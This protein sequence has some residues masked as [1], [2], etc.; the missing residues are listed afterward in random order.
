MNEKT[1]QDAIDNI[2]EYVRKMCP[3]P[4]FTHG[5]ACNKCRF[6]VHLADSSEDIMVCMGYVAR[7]AGERYDEIRIKYGVPGIP[8]EMKQENGRVY[9]KCKI[10]GPHCEG[11][12]SI[13]TNGIDQMVCLWGQERNEE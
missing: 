5:E 12:I 3:Y 9:C 8:I 10:D 6:H 2:V 7:V 11:P 13:F 1:Y 4:P